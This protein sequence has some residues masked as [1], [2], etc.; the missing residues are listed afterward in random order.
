MRH[1]ATSYDVDPA[2]IKAVV[3]T[4]SNFE[5]RAVSHV[6]AKGLMQL[7]PETQ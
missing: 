5:P 3:A 6:G 7:M 4:E 2:L 1:A